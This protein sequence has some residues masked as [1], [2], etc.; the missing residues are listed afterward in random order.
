MIVTGKHLGDCDRNESVIVTE[1]S[2]GD[3]DSK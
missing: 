1:N 3:C 2:L